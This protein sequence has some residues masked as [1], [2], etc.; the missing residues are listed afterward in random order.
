[1][2]S[3]LWCPPVFDAA[4]SGQLLPATDAVLAALKPDAVLRLGGVP[5]CRWWRDVDEQPQVPVLH[6]GSGGFR[7]LARQ[8]KVWQMPLTALA[9]VPPMLPPRRPSPPEKAQPTANTEVQMLRALLGRMGAGAQLFVGNS[10][11]IRELNQLATALPTGL[12]VAANRGANGID[13]IISTWLGMAVEPRPAGSWL[14]LGDLSAMYDWAGLWVLCQLP[15][16]PRYL[17]VVNNGGGRIF[18]GLSSL[19]GL[20][21]EAHQIMQNRHQLNFAGMAASWGLHYHLIRSAEG[22]VGVD[23]GDDGC[24][25]LELQP[26]AGEPVYNG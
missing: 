8:E 22:C 12:E 26:E 5:T 1:L 23:L 24:H 14:I 10:L 3:N 19:S 21:D 4:L 2:T 11:P 9:S 17:V 20:P 18:R 7:G 13:G 25:L 16:G 6:F 15:P